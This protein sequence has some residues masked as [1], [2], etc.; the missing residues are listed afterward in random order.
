MNKWF[1]MVKNTG[2]SAIG[3]STKSLP[4]CQEFISPYTTTH[5]GKEN[6]NSWYSVTIFGTITDWEYTNDLGVYLWLI[7]QIFPFAFTELLKDFVWGYHGSN[8]S[9]ADDACASGQIEETFIAHEAHLTKLHVYYKS[10]GVDPWPQTTNH[11]P[12]FRKLCLCSWW[13]NAEWI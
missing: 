7:Y 1:D 11:F 12:K 8:F 13:H 9:L 4:P 3:T 10:L 5:E 2:D 6:S